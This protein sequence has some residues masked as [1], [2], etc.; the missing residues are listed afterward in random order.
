MELKMVCRSKVLLYLILLLSLSCLLATDTVTLQ[1]AQ[2][3]F[4]WNFLSIVLLSV[5]LSFST[6]T[7]TFSSSSFSLPFI[8]FL[9]SSMSLFFPLLL[10]LFL[11]QTYFSLLHFLYSIFNQI[12][13]LHL[14]APFISPFFILLCFTA[15]SFHLSPSFY[16]ALFSLSSPSFHLTLH[17]HSSNIA[18]SLSDISST[19]RISVFFRWVRWIKKIKRFLEVH[20]HF[21]LWRPWT[22]HSSINSGETA[23]YFISYHIISYHRM[24]S[25]NL[26]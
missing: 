8:L 21:W 16:R 4:H 22:R 10:P 3:I 9:F 14:R 20:I 7:S 13:C 18:R 1:V 2:N 23:F 24:Q 6:S 5:I 11:S 12:A 19:R 26:L 17:S 15:P 25:F